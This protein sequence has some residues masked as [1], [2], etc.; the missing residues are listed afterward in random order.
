MRLK[1]LYLLF[2]K[3]KKNSAFPRFLP[4]SPFSKALNKKH[5]SY[6][7]KQDCD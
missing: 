5:I 3:K 2:Q 1:I 6:H 4:W 7:L